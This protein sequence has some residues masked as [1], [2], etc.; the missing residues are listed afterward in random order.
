MAVAVVLVLLAIAGLAAGRAS[1]D[2]GVAARYA[3][4]V[5]SAVT[6][7]WLRP[8]SAEAGFACTLKIE[9][10]PGGDIVAVSLVPPCDADPATRASIEQAALRA[11]PLPYRGY[12]TV[13]QRDITFTFRYDG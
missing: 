1:A 13:F 6:N 12:E 5:H 4:A 9:Q 10:L 7:A 3:A 2:D 8:R 11:A